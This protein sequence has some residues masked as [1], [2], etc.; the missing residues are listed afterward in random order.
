MIYPDHKNGST[1]HFVAEVAGWYGAAAIITAYGLATFGYINAESYAY[2][3]LN[4]SGAM[5]IMTLAVFKHVRQSVV[6]NI[7]WMTIAII[8]IFRLSSN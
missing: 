7:F 3:L 4:L 2:Q 1:T 5:G 6:V 8:G